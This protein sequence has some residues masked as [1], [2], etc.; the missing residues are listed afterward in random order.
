[1]REDIVFMLKGRVDMAL[2]DLT[3]NQLLKDLTL[4]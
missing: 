2:K 4:T 3:P 1:M